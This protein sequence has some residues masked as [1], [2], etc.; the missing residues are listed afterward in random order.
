MTYPQAVGRLREFVVRI[1]DDLCI[2]VN[3]VR[4]LLGE[5]AFERM[6][7]HGETEFPRPGFVSPHDACAWLV[8]AETEKCEGRP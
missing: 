7:L 2:H 8:I 6:V 4:P 1:G 3:N 5:S